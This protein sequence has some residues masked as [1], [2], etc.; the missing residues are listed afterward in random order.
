MLPL[1]LTFGSLDGTDSLF[2]V[3]DVFKKYN[4]YLPRFVGFFEKHDT[5]EFGTVSLLTALLDTLDFVRVVADHVFYH[6][7]HSC[8]I[9]RFNDIFKLFFP[10]TGHMHLLVCTSVHLNPFFRSTSTVLFKTHQTLSGFSVPLPWE[11]RMR[12]SIRYYC[13]A[14]FF[15]TLVYS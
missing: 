5:K 8:R 6:R 3:L 2:R 11:M 15:H 14:L 10:L 9:G 7:Y 1:F 12:E 13:V 4:V